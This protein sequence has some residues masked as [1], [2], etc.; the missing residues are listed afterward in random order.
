MQTFQT[1]QQ[2]WQT[3]GPQNGLVSMTQMRNTLSDTL[4]LS[5]FNNVDR[6]YAPMTAENE[7]QLMAQMAQSRAAASSSKVSRAT[8]WHRH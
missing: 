3:Y 7:Q 2:I 8:Q 6:Y 5:G 1:Q 4:A